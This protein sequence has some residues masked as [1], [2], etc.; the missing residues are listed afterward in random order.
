MLYSAYVKTT[1][2]TADP[3]YCVFSAERDSIDEFLDELV[4]IYQDN[5]SQ[6][7]NSTEDDIAAEK[8]Y[9]RDF[10]VELISDGE[11]EETILT[12]LVESIQ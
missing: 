5:A 12:V 8:F 3:C 6:H 9:N 10:D 11:T 7:Y 4:T 1:K 2:E